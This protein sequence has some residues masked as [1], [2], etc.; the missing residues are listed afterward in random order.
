[1]THTICTFNVNN[2]YTR[3]K[4]GKTFPGDAAK[5]SGVA[6]PSKGFLPQYSKG[7]FEIFN[8]EQRQLAAQALTND[9]TQFPDV[10]CLQEVESLLTLR[11]FNEEFLGNAYPY[12]LLIDSRDFRQIDVAILSR[13][14]ILSTR[15]HVD[16]LDPQPES[17]SQ[18]WLFSRDCVEVNLGL[19]KSGLR[20]LT[21]FINHLKSKF[22]TPDV[23]G[24]PAKIAAKTAEDNAKRR[25]QAEGIRRI[26]RDRYPGGAFQ[27]A[28]FAVVGDMNDHLGSPQLQ[29]LFKNIGLVDALARIPNEADRWTHWWR[30]KNEV[31]QLDHM[32]LS[33]ALAKATEGTPPRLERRGIGFQRVLATGQPGPKETHF[34]RADDDPSPVSVGFQFERFPKVTTNQYA[35]DHCPI[36]FEAP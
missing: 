14:E 10:I 18:P 12:A 6:D 25:R 35:S 5:K 31:S 33:P 8:P 9:H 19:N 21:L 32:L 20:V 34:H 1:M 24:N 17:P 3:Y 26:L 28:L 2:L 29:P 27:Q 7:F 13:L 23:A 30:S 16:D 36:F 11:Q 22:V 15:S 4:F